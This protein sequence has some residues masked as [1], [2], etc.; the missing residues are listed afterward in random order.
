MDYARQNY[1]AQPG[2]GLEPKDY[3]RRL[4][5]F[6]DFIINW[7]YRVL[8]NAATPEAEKA[9]LN[10]WLAEQTGPMPYR[11]LPQ[12]SVG[13]DP[14]AQTEDIG[15][16]AVRSSGYAV[17]NLKRMLPNL[18][19]W[20]TQPGEDYTEL[21]ELYG[22]TL[23]M[24]SQYMGHVT[25]WIGGLTINLKTADQ[26][27]P[28]YSVVPKARQKAA[29]QFLSEQ[30]IRTPSW[31]QQPDVLARIGPPLGANSLANRQAGVLTQLMDARRLA[32]LLESQSMD[33]AN[34]YPLDEY[35]EELR[36]AVWTGVPDANRRTLHRVYL[37]RLET[38]MAPPAAAPQ[39]GGPGGGPGFQ[40]PPLL[41]QPNVRR[42]DIS[43]LAR[44]QLRAIQAQARRL[45][46]ASTGVNRAHWQDID[47][48]IEVII[49][50]EKSR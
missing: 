32:R 4:G 7:G 34:A 38:L 14:R 1:V 30:A 17:Q 31:L 35:L 21:A 47:A 19:A 9:T 15:D 16:D 48:R 29:L 20:T 40:I 46:A 12:F 50:N 28:V 5:P 13:I 44:A 8:P 43:A 23:G 37:E 42:A 6:D 3:I 24:W 10:K 36:S 45:G 26:S 27:G 39:G 18:V 25:N 49:E 33:P 41:Q 2:D 11:Y 22:E